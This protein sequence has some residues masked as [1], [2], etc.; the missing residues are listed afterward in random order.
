LSHLPTRACRVTT[1]HDVAWRQLGKEYL[2]VVTPDW[3]DA[4]E[5]AIEESDH[6]IA[7]SHATADELIAGGMAPSRI[8]VA[9]LGVEDRFRGVGADDASRVRA[10]YR[11][12]ERF[13]LY[14]GAINVRKNFDTLPGALTLMRQPPLLVIIGPPPAALSLPAQ[15]SAKHL[16]YIPEEDVAPLYAAARLLIF[17]SLI[18][19]FGLPLLEAM[20][21]GVPVVASRIPVFQEVGGDAPWY[22]DPTDSAALCTALEAVLDDAAQRGRMIQSGRRQSVA[23][24]WERC[25]SATV[26]GYRRALGL[27]DGTA[28]RVTRSGVA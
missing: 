20:A 6:L 25:A 1:V 15:V 9:P 22:F 3:V 28:N 5:R 4:A 8:T 19:G 12:P 21:A 14:A 13:I 23:F 11:L 18:E 26:D 17:P 10:R 27:A 24:T 2:T 16:G 7:D